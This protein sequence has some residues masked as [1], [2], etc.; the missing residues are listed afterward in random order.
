MSYMCVFVCVRACVF[1]LFLFHGSILLFDLAYSPITTHTHSLSLSLSLSL[2]SL[3]R[4][5]SVIVRQ[6]FD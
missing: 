6:V 4:T 1:L 5:N 3:A 2:S